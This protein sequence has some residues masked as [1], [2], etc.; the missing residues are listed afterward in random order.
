V[1][2]RKKTKKKECI[3][4]KATRKR[5]ISDSFTMLGL[6]R[7]YI[8]LWIHKKCLEKVGWDNLSSFLQENKEMWYNDR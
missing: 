5:A 6:D 7:P 2:P 4:C 3:Y 8:N 1:R